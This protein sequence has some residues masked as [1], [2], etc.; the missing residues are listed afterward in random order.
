MTYFRFQPP[1][2]SAT[3]ETIVGALEM[4]VRRAK[5]AESRVRVL[6]EALTKIRDKGKESGNGKLHEVVA[7]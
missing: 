2:D 6:E 5:V 3:R 7:G 1:P 4:W